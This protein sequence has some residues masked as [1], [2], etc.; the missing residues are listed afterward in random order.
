[1]T[2]QE[3]MNS[4]H[5]EKN[6]S[7]GNTAVYKRLLE[8]I[9]SNR[10]I[11][12]IGA[13]LSCWAGYPTWNCLLTEI[14]KGMPVESKVKDLLNK[15]QY[16]QAASVLEKCCKG[17][18]LPMLEEV[19]SADKLDSTKRPQFQ[20]LMPKLFNGPFVTTNYDVSLERLL[21]S[22]FMVTPDDSYDEDA[23]VSKLQ[24]HKRIL[25]KLHG[26]IDSSA[27]M[28]LTEKRYN[29]AYGENA[30]NPDMSLP[31][32]RTLQH[33]FHSDIPFFL[34]CGMGNDRTCTVFKKCCGTKGFA[35]LELPKETENEKNPFHP[36]LTNENG[37]IPELDDRMDFLSDMQLQI[38]WYPH[39]KHEAVSV[40]IEQL[41][42]DLSISPDPITREEKKKTAFPEIIGSAPYQQADYYIG[43]DKI[44][45]TVIR[46]LLK[47]TSCYLYGIGGI[48]KTEIAKDVYKR[49]KNIPKVESGIT[50]LLWVDYIENSFAVS[51]VKAFGLNE[52]NID[53]AFNTAVKKI[54]QYG[55]RLLLVIDNVEQTNDND[56]LRVSCYLNCRILITSRC[57]G[58]QRIKQIEVPPL[59][60]Q[61]CRDLFM[62]YYHGS[63]DIF[64]LNQIIELTDKHTVTI[65]LLSKIADC[66]EQ[67][68][69]DFLQT[70]IECGFN[71]S[72]E[73]VAAV[74]EKLQS[75]DRVIEQLKK[76][77]EVYGF[78]KNEE[79]L[80]VQI[81]TIPNLPFSFYQ[82]KRWFNQKNRTI[83]NNLSKKG[84]LK[85]ETMYN[86][87][88]NQYRYVMHSVIAAAVRAQFLDC[89]YENCQDFIR[90]ITIDMQECID[91][92]DNFK[93]GLIQFSWS[94]ND[95]FRNSFSN[96]SDCDFLWALSEI[97][98]DIGLYARTIPILDQ[99]M[100]L[101]RLLYGND[102][103]PMGS[104]WNSKGM[105]AFQLS[106]FEEAL[107][108]YLQSERILKKRSE[109]SKS[110]LVDIARLKLNIGKIYLKIDYQIAEPYINEAYEILE[111]NLGSDQNDT[112]NALTHKAE[113]QRKKG[114]NEQAEAI[115]MDVINRI[116]NKKDRDSLL[117]KASTSHALGNL[118]SDTDPEKAMPYFETARDIFT[119][120][121]SPTNPDTIDVVNS[122][123]SLKLSL[124]I[125]IDNAL[126][127]L[128]EL[129]PI[130]I[131]T[132]SHDDPNTAVVIVNIGLGYY[133]LEQYED[134]IKY[135]NE[136]LD[137][138]HVVY[139]DENEEFAYI[140]NNIGGAYSEN[141]E[142]EKA[143]PYHIKAINIL[144]NVYQGE[145]NFDLAQSY[146]ELADAYI[147]LKM[148]DE[149]KKQLN[150]CFEMYDGWIEQ[151][152]YR[153]IQ[154]YST[155]G[156]IYYYLNDLA[157][158]KTIFLHVIDL[159]KK[160]NYSDNS[161]EVAQYTQ[162]IEEINRKNPS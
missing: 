28:I 148:I 124:R 99:L 40:L 155:L 18:F 55:D 142:P 71:I 136:A 108:C 62:H 20:K 114:D 64:S 157:N 94:L 2:F 49:I 41:A 140:Y 153:Y 129:L 131:K 47:R 39:G 137:I 32:P 46:H 92:N 88:S 66:T 109:E 45:D 98:R 14:S 15:E 100:S 38:I 110:A 22:P 44:L 1:M 117:L 139:Q 116:E 5:F 105:A 146:S 33:I 113:I 130:Y 82:A 83:L 138:Y 150:K 126:S 75:E 115:F 61:L 77:F 159:L 97:Y 63:E 60:D 123:C 54:N 35:L 56:L 101:Y 154:P 81:S 51:L 79:N 102:C 43:R 91:K 161:P 70:L 95:I 119:E 74:H 13:G 42:A 120:L 12:V 132:Y 24:S 50:H 6:E 133:Y 21:N 53:T 8:A 160:N 19:F 78:S 17:Y 135:Y 162:I 134:A 48:G 118:Y 127:D 58:Y 65:E 128:L 10:V 122:I 141:N 85:K 57:Q 67:S 149:T 84:W 111:E 87:T 143:I 151:T 34:G 59:D 125:N 69:C 30:E 16:E 25:V 52:I 7:L 31:L 36:C 23:F 112:L 107:N 80:L 152:S 26:T 11:P 145:K 147:R 93:K 68:L 9:K 144:E 29:E 103:L 89:L 121:L 106:H 156:T 90:E 158:A 3:L 104:V 86:N 76:L 73:E 4:F 96:E 27:N 37:W 72:D